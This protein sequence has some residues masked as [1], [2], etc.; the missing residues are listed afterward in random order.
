MSIRKI[1]YQVTAEGIMPSVVQSG[2]V[3]GEHNATELSFTLD[4]ALLSA[5]RETAKEQSVVYRFDA[6]SGAGAKY[7]TTPQDLPDGDAVTLAYRLENRLTRDGGNIRVYLVITAIKDDETA[8]DLYSFPALIR[9]TNTPVGKEGDGENYESLSTL[10]EIAKESAAEAVDAKDTA[11]I[12]KEQTVLAHTALTDGAEFIFDGGD[13]ESEISI[14]LTV[15]AELNAV[16]ENPVQNKAVSV[17]FAELESDINEQMGELTQ[18]AAS[19]SD[20]ISE[21]KQTVQETQQEFDEHKEALAD[22][23]VEQGTSGIWTYRKWASGIAEC[24]GVGNEILLDTSNEPWG[25]I[26]TSG[27]NHIPRVEYP[28]NFAE[29]PLEFVAPRNGVKN[30]WV[31]MTSTSENLNNTDTHTGEYQIARG[32]SQTDILVQLVYHVIGR[33]K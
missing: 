16:S 24:W 32:T 28:F 2:G 10:A 15:D 6:Y 8:L 1:E 31:V 29:Q 5:I 11:L 25:S 14:D 20:A 4:G 12:A 9:L 3:Q 19:N 23:I 27:E 22:Y 13:A 7:S 26:Y 17:R 18:A 33:W 30:F 21:V